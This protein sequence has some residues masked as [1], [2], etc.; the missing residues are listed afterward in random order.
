MKRFLALALFVGLSSFS[1]LGCTNEEKPA[2]PTTPAT[3]TAPAAPGAPGETP[4]PG[5]PAPAP[6]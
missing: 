6:K 2:A 1:L 3:E 5:A 4:A